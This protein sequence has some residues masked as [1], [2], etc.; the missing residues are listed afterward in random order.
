[1]NRSA[2]PDNSV[3]VEDEELIARL[4]GGDDDALRELFSRHAPM[5]ATRL[6]AMLP[7]ADVQDILQET[8][9][10]AWRGA[11]RYR[12]ESP[13]GGWLWGIA[14][15]QAVQSLRRRGPVNLSLSQLLDV[16]TSD[17]ANSAVSRVDLESA[18]AALGP[19]GSPER[20]VWRLL[21]LEDR[22]VAEVAALTGVPEGTVKSRAYRARRLLRA[23]LGR[24]LAME[25]GPR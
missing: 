21:Y 25:G 13:A 16:E 10:A 20:E 23:V 18:V 22:P 6:R 15:L 9:V 19:P 11:H 8:F 1:M 2:P 5:L 3:A 14:R 7:P 24:H 12:A 4:A 17:F